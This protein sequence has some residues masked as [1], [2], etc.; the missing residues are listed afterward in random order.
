MTTI[1]RLSSVDALQASD[2]FPLYDSSNGD[3]RKVS[4][5]VLSD[6]VNGEGADTKT[7]Q[8]ASPSATGFAVVV[9]SG[10]TYLLLTPVD[11]YASGTIQFPVAIDKQ[12]V[13]VYCSKQL[14]SLSVTGTSVSFAGA[15]ESLAAGSFFTMRFD[16]ASDTWYRVG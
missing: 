1:N 2:N 4:L 10:N 11:A 16:D 3:A 5:S 14:S 9:T 6:Y 13:T 12:E 15:P 8:T 7:T